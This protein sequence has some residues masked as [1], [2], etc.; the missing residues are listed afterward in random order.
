MKTRTIKTPP[1][2]G[3]RSRKEIREAVMKVLLRRREKPF[4]IAIFGDSASRTCSILCKGLAEYLKT[5][6]RVEVV[7]VVNSGES[8]L[9]HMLAGQSCGWSAFRYLLGKLFGNPVV[10]DHYG[11]FRDIF[12]RSWQKDY[13]DGKINNRKEI[14]I[15]KTLN[16]DGAICIGTPYKF[17]KELLDVLGY[18]VNYHDSYLPEYA[19]RGATKM[20][21]LNGEEKSGFTFHRMVERCDAGNIIWQ[22]NV[23][24]SDMNAQQ[25]EIIKARH[26][27]CHWTPVIKAMLEN[28]EGTP[29][30][31]SIRTYYSYKDWLEAITVKREKSQRRLDI[32]GYIRVWHKHQYVYVTSLDP[33]RIFYLPVGLWDIVSRFIKVNV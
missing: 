33:L 6:K 21:Y 13:P 5:D 3:T 26:A 25:V 11:D 16:L 15:F 29:Q 8:G 23:F 31:L 22:A 17:S 28:K 1:E 19:G 9:L 20:A 24:V 30:D 2:V 4:R 27:K 14:R 32:F 10:W 18:V 12:W 7:A